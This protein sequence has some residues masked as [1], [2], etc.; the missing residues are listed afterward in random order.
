[1]KLNIQL[2]LAELSFLNTVFI[3]GIFGV[4]CA[5]STV[6]NWVHKAELQ[7]RYGQD[8]DYVAVDET[9][10][11]LND[12]QYWL[13]AAVDPKTNKVLY[14][15]LE[16]MINKVISHTFFAELREKHDIND[17]SRNLWVLVC[18]QDAAR[19]VNAVFLIDD[20]HSLK[21]ASRR[22]GLDFGYERHENR[23]NI[24]WIFRELKRRIIGL[25]NC[26]S[27]TRAETPADWLRS[28]SF[29]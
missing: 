13:Y 4:K 7:S 6:D 23:S 25:L 20:S 11:Q 18:E 14:T 12:E 29:A 24:K 26:F 22:Y 10:I 17:I 27:N 16:P 19:L 1:M 9:V 8:P 21:D 15:N 5:R 2:H 28:F 3:I